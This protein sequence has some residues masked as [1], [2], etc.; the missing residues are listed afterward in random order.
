MSTS[1]PSADHV[2]EC[3]SG[4]ANVVEL[5]EASTLVGSR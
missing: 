3:G 1:Q 2:S 5:N 4:Y